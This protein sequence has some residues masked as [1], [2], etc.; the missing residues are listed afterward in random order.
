M[1]D[2]L[3]R[4]RDFPA[5]A[6]ADAGYQLELVQAG[7]PPAD[8]RPMPDVGPGTVEIRVH[9]GSEYRVFLV[10]RFP[11]AVYVLHA[12]VK[13]TRTTRQADLDLGRQRYRALL[14][15][16]MSERRKHEAH[17]QDREN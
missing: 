7:E 2:S 3:Q 1:G 17:E 4:L 10:A 15:R 8:F 11:E 14:E 6:R 12:F 5:D 16:R 9:S 13:K